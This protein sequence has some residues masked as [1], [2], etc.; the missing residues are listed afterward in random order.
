MRENDGLMIMGFKFVDSARLGNL[1]NKSNGVD[2]FITGRKKELY[3]DL[4]SLIVDVRDEMILSTMSSEDVNS[5]GK[6]L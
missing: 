5:F 6:F 1:D 2:V 4:L 3:F